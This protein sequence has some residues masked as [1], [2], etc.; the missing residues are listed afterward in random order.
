MLLLRVLAKAET[1]LECTIVL[2]SA[3]HN[4]SFLDSALHNLS[5]YLKYFYRG[6]P[7]N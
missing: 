3:L 1:P 5:L 2:F 4:L 7:F 6:K